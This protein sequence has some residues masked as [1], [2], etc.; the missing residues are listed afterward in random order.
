LALGVF[1]AM[2]L[3]GGLLCLLAA[4]RLMHAPSGLFSGSLAEI[5]RD[6]AA[7]SGE[8]AAKP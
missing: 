4:R 7:L 3:S 2:F 1:S 8:D 6:R 5:S